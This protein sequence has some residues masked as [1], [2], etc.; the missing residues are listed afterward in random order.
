[1]SEEENRD[2]DLDKFEQDARV[3]AQGMSAL[4]RRAGELGVSLTFSEFYD[5]DRVD[6]VITVAEPVTRT[7]S[8]ETGRRTL[9]RSRAG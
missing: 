4:K 9:D 1:M 7:V 6:I 2:A 3:V 8:V 5:T